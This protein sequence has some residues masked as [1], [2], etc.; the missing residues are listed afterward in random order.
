MGTVMRLHQTPLLAAYIKK[1]Y[2]QNSKSTE[3]Q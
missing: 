2:E 3:E 1:L